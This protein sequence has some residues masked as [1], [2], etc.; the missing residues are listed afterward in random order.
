[1]CSGISHDPLQRDIFTPL[2]LGATIHIPNAEDIG[3]PGQ[4][5]VWMKNHSI[6]VSHLTPAMGQ[7][8][9]ETMDNATQVESLRLT[10]FVGDKLT[11]RDVIRLRRVAPNVTCINMYG[12]TETQRAVSYYVVPSNEELIRK[13]EIL[14]SGK[15]MKDVQLIILNSAGIVVQ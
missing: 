12:S 4:L 10:L 6:T 15:G 1:M 14:S 9:S 13:K 5:A 11:K 2:F 8:L 7:L 3:N